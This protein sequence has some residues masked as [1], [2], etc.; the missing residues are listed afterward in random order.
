MGLMRASKQAFFEYRAKLIGG[1]SIK[2]D[3]EDD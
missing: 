1:E 3:D 2:P